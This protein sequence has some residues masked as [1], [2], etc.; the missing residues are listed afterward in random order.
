MIHA[1]VFMWSAPRLG[2]RCQ[3]EVRF[4]GAVEAT[5]ARSAPRLGERCQIEVRFAG[6]VEATHARTAG[7][8]RSHG[9]RSPPIR[10]AI[11]LILRDQD[12]KRI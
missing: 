7:S 5:H 8:I 9:I 3:I 6:A 1:G 10:Q 2:E 12:G 11:T 4:A